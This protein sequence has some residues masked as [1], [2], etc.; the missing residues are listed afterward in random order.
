MFYV[1]FRSN[2]FAHKTFLIMKHEKI[3]LAFCG[4]TA[5]LCFLQIK[6]FIIMKKFF[7]KLKSKSENCANFQKKNLPKN[8]YKKK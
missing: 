3:T 5:L 8:I 7:L 4:K 1:Y 2:F 6:H